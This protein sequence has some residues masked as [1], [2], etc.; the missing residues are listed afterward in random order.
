MNHPVY[1]DLIESRDVRKNYISTV[2]INT[3]MDWSITHFAIGYVDYVD[4]RA[5][6]VQQYVHKS[7]IID[8]I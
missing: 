4:Y 1:L 7:V 2:R 5:R 3:G 8:W 6:L